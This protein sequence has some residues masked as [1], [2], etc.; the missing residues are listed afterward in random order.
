MSTGVRRTYEP[1]N[2]PGSCN[3]CDEP[4]LHLQEAYCDA[5]QES[6]GLLCEP[7]YARANRWSGE[8]HLCAACARK[9]DREKRARDIEEDIRVSAAVER[10]QEWRHRR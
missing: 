7:C 5:C 8:P 4:S 3:V 1:P 6:T 2:K 9:L 10:D